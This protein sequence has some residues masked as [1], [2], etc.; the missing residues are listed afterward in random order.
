MK[1]KVDY[2]LNVYRGFGR[3]SRIIINQCEAILLTEDVYDYI[4]RNPLVVGIDPL[5]YVLVRSGTLDFKVTCIPHSTKFFYIELK[6]YR[7]F[8]TDRQNNFFK[9]ASKLNIPCEKFYETKEQYDYRKMMKF[10]KIILDSNIFKLYDI[11]EAVCE[12]IQK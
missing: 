6:S 7:Q 12:M 4:L 5:E 11:A 10:E 2:S 3:K 1:K 8:L 9:I